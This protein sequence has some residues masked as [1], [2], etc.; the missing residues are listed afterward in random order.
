MVSSDKPCDI[1]INELVYV[2][3]FG[4]HINYKCDRFLVEKELNFNDPEGSCWFNHGA[5]FCDEYVNPK[6]VD[7]DNGKLL[8]DGD[9]R[10]HYI[11]DL[12]EVMSIIG[13]T[14]PK[15][16]DKDRIVEFAGVRK[17]E[18]LSLG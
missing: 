15:I 16:E 14:S 7:Y 12:F 5:L 2:S 9:F 4:K 8:S 18:K 3:F 1:Y 11:F 13:V 10:S 17:K 6:G